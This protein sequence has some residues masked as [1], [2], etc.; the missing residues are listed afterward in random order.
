MTVPSYVRESVEELKQLAVRHGNQPQEK[1]LRMLLLLKTDPDKRHVDIAHQLGCSART[2]SRWM[3]T[4]RSG[5][6][7]AL[8]GS[9]KR[10]RQQNDLPDSSASSKDIPGHRRHSGG[11]FAWIIQD[12]LIRALNQLPIDADV[13]AWGRT[14]RD[15]LQEA[16]EDVDRITVN[17]NMNCDLLRPDEYNP[18]LSISQDAFPDDDHKGLAIA[19][20]DTTESYAGENLIR[21]FQRQGYPVDEYHPPFILNLE[22][23]GAYLGTLF[24]WRGLSEVPISEETIETLSQLEEFLV[25][26]MSD[27]ILRHHYIAPVERAFYSTLREITAQAALTAQEHRVITYRMLGYMY[28]EI[29]AEL[30]ISQDAVKKTLQQIYRKTG[31]GSHIEF[32]AKYFTIRV[33]PPHS[34]DT[35]APM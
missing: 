9:R 1:R 12:R 25:Y 3:H 15:V 4:Y 18:R 17:V 2:V 29:A 19:R 34:P 24:L 8:L 6:L 27:V 23:R 33:I 32:F 5:G 30:N 22:Y 31:T 11:A 21:E 16:F 14:V 28:K 35:D 13:G 10:S 20:Y 7:P 26:A